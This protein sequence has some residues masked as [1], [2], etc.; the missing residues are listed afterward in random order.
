[1]EDLR[2]HIDD[3]EKV[4]LPKLDEAL[5]KDESIEL[6]QSF[7]RTKY[8]V[9]TRAHSWTPQRPPYETAIGLMTAPIDRLADVFRKW[10]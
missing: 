4:G 8:F 5:S 6:A 9:P 1:M 10:P 2:H 3:E 7:D